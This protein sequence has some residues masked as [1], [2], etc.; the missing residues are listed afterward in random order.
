MLDTTQPCLDHAGQSWTD[1]AE[2]FPG[3]ARL[4]PGCGNCESVASW[5]VLSRAV[6]TNQ[7][8]LMK[9]LTLHSAPIGVLTNLGTYCIGPHGVHHHIE[10]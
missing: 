1:I 10:H 2:C 3:L 8:L 5:T 4:R 6:Q 7:V 9:V